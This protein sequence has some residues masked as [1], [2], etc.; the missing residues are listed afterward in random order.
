MKW[1]E[2]NDITEDVNKYIQRSLLRAAN[3]CLV[4]K[5]FGG[6][7]IDWN[8]YPWHI[9]FIDWL[10]R[11]KDPIAPREIFKKYG[12]IVRFRRHNPFTT[13]TNQEGYN[14]DIRIR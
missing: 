12:K 9:K 7:E 11:V 6:S 3:P 5:R 14:D 2:H 13:I 4:L 1:I 8:D 10:F